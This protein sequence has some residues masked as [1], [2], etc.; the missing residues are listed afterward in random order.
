MIE[1]ISSIHHIIYNT[2][3]IYHII[4]MTSIIKYIIHITS[5]SILHHPD[6]VMY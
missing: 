2:S 5:S 6:D 1:Y 3:S 4:K